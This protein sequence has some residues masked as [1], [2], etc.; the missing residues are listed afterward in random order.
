MDSIT[1]YRTT[2]LGEELNNTINEFKEFNIINDEL[3]DKI[4]I[5]FDK[6]IKI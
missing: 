6:V 3:S 4:K 1:L 2:K 5:M